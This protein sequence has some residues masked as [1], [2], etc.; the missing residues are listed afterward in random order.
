[1]WLQKIGGST[2]LLFHFLCLHIDDAVHLALPYNYRLPSAAIRLVRPKESSSFQ[3]T[4]AFSSD[5]RPVSSGRA[6]FFAFPAPC[7]RDHR[8][9]ARRPDQILAAQSANAGIKAKGG[10]S[11]PIK[12]ATL[13]PHHQAG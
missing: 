1:M 5:A 10:D 3:E 6:S 8:R 9:G 7:I 2:I 4:R 13:A 12:V 11:G